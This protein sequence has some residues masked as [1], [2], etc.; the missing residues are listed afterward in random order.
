MCAQHLRLDRDNIG[1]VQREAK[2]MAKLRGHPNI[3]RLHAVAFAGPKGSETDG[4]FL[5]D[6][7]VSSSSAARWHGLGGGLLVHMLLCAQRI[8]VRHCTAQTPCALPA[9]SLACLHAAARHAAGPDGSPQVHAGEPHH[10]SHLQQRVSRS[11]SHA[12]PEA[13]YGTQVGARV[14]WGWEHN[15]CASGRTQGA[16]LQAGLS[17]APSAVSTSVVCPAGT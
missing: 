2:T 6:Y 4:F 7:C 17:D 13:T 5:L 16:V 8:T 9:V 12:P 3:L 14:Q 10:H 11:G 15:S 1:E